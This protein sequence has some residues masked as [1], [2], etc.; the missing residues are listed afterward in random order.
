[1][2]SILTVIAGTTGVHIASTLLGYI[3][4]SDKD[5]LS[6]EMS[7]FVENPQDLECDLQ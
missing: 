7:V 6:I 1:V 5:R 4:E 3:V 2:A